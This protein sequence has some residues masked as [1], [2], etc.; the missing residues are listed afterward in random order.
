ML[1]HS[2]ASRCVPTPSRP[3]PSHPSH[4]ISSDLVLSHHI[5]SHPIP[6]R[7]IPS[8]SMST[9]SIPPHLCT[10]T[11]P[12]PITSHPV[13]SHRIKEA[14]PKDA[15]KDKWDCIGGAVHVAG[16]AAKEVDRTWREYHAAAAPKTEE[17]CALVKSVPTL[18]HCTWTAPELHLTAL[19]CT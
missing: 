4:P 7:P 2:V 6:R 3:I 11:P 10:Y 8:C 9:C 18:L 16:T 14:P 5:L 17:V 19:D 13:P 15:P 1:Y 12:L